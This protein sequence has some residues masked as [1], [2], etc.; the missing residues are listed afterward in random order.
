MSQPPQQPPQGGYGAP[1]D[2][3]DG[4]TP[5]YGDAPGSHAQQPA[6]PGYGYPQ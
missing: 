4:S 3:H 2:P 1:Q 6:P 5:G